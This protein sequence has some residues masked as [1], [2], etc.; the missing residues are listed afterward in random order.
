MKLYRIVAIDVT[1]REINPPPYFDVV[2]G[3]VIRAA[4]AKAARRL[5]SAEAG[6]EGKDLWLDPKRSRVAELTADGPKMVIL[7][8]GTDA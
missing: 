7:A 8:E 4:S 1:G 3:F 2:S 5:A 6:D